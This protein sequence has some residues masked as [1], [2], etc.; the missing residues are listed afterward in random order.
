ME[1]LHLMNKMI[2]QIWLYYLKLKYYDFWKN[3]S[4]HFFNTGKTHT[5][6]S[7]LAN[8]ESKSQICV[9]LKH[10]IIWQIWV[11]MLMGI[12]EYLKKFFH[13]NQFQCIRISRSF[14]ITTVTSEVRLRKVGAGK[15]AKVNNP[16]A[17]RILRLH[18]R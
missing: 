11:S 5:K 4:I 8:Q 12:K 15:L 13:L 10:I 16:L 3:N 2:R 14:P 6:H 17:C 7:L 9:N 18:S 1:C